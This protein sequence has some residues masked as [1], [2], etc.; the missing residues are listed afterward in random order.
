M[1]YSWK[2]PMKVPAETA[3]KVIEELYEKNGSV[4]PSDVV[5]ASREEGTPLHDLFEWDDSIAAEKYRE[6]QARF[7]I[8]NI[9]RVEENEKISPVRSFVHV[10]KNYV[11]LSVALSSEEMKATLF[12]NALADFEIFRAKYHNLVAFAEVFAAFDAIEKN[13]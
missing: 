1:V 3:A 10:E 2:L 11:P 6:T 4:T 9:Q 5:N 13:V 7:I 12:Q 8:R